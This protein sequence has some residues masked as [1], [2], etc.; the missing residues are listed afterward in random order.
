LAT[1]R[2]KNAV[3]ISRIVIKVGTSTLT[4][5]ETSGPDR[6]F[7]NT[8]ATQIAEQRAAGREVIL[9]TSGAIRAGV[10][11]LRLTERPTTIPGKQAAASVG[12]SVLMALYADIFANYGIKVGQVLLTKEDIEQPERA[13]NAKNTFDALLSLQV[14][15]I[16]NENDTVA[17]EEIRVGDNDTLAAHVGALVGADTIFLLSDV[18]GLY[19]K[20]PANH[21]DAQLIREVTTIDD[22]LWKIAGGTG[23]VQGTGGMTTK[24]QAAQIAQQAGITLWIAEGRLPGVL[25]A[26]L[27][28]VTGTRF[29]PVIASN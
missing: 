22:T 26:C 27:D 9:V 23:T 16:V 28:G 8:L 10:V 21:A 29:V 12:Q 2:I 18:A 4:G 7:I 1:T 14:L 3:G 24:L 11:H 13:T 5:S 19:D 6:V 17:T 15:P 20:N 25:R